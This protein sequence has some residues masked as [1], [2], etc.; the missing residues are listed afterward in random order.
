[1]NNKEFDESVYDIYNQYIDHVCGYVERTNV[2]LPD[3]SQ[4]EPDEKFMRPIEEDVLIAEQYVND[5]RRQVMSFIGAMV[6]RGRDHKSLINPRLQSGCASYCCGKIQWGLSPDWF[7]SNAVLFSRN[8][9]SLTERDHSHLQI[10]ADILQ[11]A[12]CDSEVILTHLRTSQRH[13]CGIVTRL[14]E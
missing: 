11:D 12:G 10:L 7:T 5:F 8:F 13:N 2:H 9:L 1:M 3:G 4:I 6:V 14:A